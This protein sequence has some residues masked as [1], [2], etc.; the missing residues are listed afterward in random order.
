LRFEALS[1]DDLPVLDELITRFPY[2]PYRHYRIL[3]RRRQADVLRALIRQPAEG[4]IGTAFV[5]SS[6]GSAGPHAACLLRQLDWETEFF[7][8]PMGRLESMLGSDANPEALRG[9]LGTVVA[10]ARAQGVVHLAAR[11]DIADCRTVHM[12]EDLGFRLMDT[13]VTYIYGR[14]ERPPE[15]VRNMGL[16][17]PYEPKDRDQLL[18]IA[19]EAYSDFK[20][21][22]HNDP[23][24]ADERATAM[25]VEWARRCVDGE[26]AEQILV[27]EDGN[28]YLH[29][30]A[31]FRRIEPVSTVGGVGVYG[32]GLG[33]CRRQRPG[34]YMGLLQGATQWIY[35][36]GAVTEC[37]TQSFNF[38]T[39]R[40]YEAL[41]QR[42]VRAEHTFHVQL[43]H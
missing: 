13:L 26:W 1:S 38:P 29:G 25:Y 19:A 12:L 10:E 34:A 8:L 23:H 18:E 14:K 20:G 9:L 43:G 11:V 31:T 30:F 42:F 3:S 7:G 40:L 37:Q 39:I 41:A 21:R 27:T 6:R 17:R 5:A 4:G 32:G 22:Y 24:L 36:K 2:N 15:D 35:V 16:Q 33:G 28:G